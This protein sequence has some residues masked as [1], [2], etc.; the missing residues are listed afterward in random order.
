[1]CRKH[2]NRAQQDARI[3]GFIQ[4]EQPSCPDHPEA[5]VKITRFDQ[6][7]PLLHCHRPT[8]EKIQYPAQG[9]G[10]LQ[11][12]ASTAHTSW[13]NW[14]I[15]IPWSVLSGIP[16]QGPPAAH[17]ELR[18]GPQETL[19]KLGST[20]AGQ[21]PEGTLLGKRTMPGK[22]H[23]TL[24]YLGNSTQYQLERM[25]AAAEE[26]T[27]VVSQAKLELGTAPGSFPLTGDPGR[28][29]IW[30]D[31]KGDTELLQTARLK[32]DEAAKE[33]GYQSA[34]W[35]FTP[36]ITLG[37]LTAPEGMMEEALEMWRETAAGAQG[38]GWNAGE[39]RL[40]TKERWENRP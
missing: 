12:P 17:I 21:L 13:C 26:A 5:A 39:A 3:E 36:H 37:I 34:G 11:T 33:A 8:G 6:S 23:I 18:P 24:R 32:L 35:D 20:L 14:G 25:E 10:R 40:V 29:V 4:K 2:L 27:R 9:K 31:V 38:E 22:H 7:R 15:D 16:A 1:M 19:R 30:A 28:R